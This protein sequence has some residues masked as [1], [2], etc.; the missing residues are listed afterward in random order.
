MDDLIAFVRACLDREERVARSASTFPYD[1]PSDAPWE[2][3]RQIAASI[4]G[5][6]AAAVHDHI[7]LHDPA[8]ALADVA[9]KRAVLD[10]FELWVREGHAW[11]GLE[12]AVQ[13]L[14]QA[15]AGWDGWQEAWRATPAQ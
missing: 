4:P 12:R 14:A 2:R 9:A 3:A 7:A 15:Y 6:H 8:H 1:H 13:L 5:S 10:E 11:A